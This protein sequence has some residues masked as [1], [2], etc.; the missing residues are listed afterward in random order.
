MRFTERL[1]IS[2]TITPE[3]K[4]LFGVGIDVVLAAEVYGDA[5]I[6]IKFTLLDSSGEGVNTVDLIGELE[7]SVDVAGKTG[8][9]T[10]AYKTWH[11]YTSTPKAKLESEKKYPIKHIYRHCMICLH[12]RRKICHI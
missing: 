5:K 11:L 1:K 7:V 12:I 4:A 2:T 6:P 3:V 9:K 10:F 8:S